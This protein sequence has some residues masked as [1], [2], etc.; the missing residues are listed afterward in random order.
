MLLT[1]VLLV[2]A[3]GG[4]PAPMQSAIDG[5]ALPSS[6]QIAKAVV[7]GGSSPCLDVADAYCPSV[8]RYYTVDGD[9]PDL[10][11]E[12]RRALLEG[13]FGQPS[14]LFPNCD[15]PST[16]GGLCSISGSRGDLRIRVNLYPPGRN[17]GVPDVAV[18]GQA[19]VRITVY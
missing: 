6:W 13:G 5:L 7:R 4:D 2:S 12:A 19:T 15:A 14:E 11:N 9:L 10:F 17:A 8:T 1:L 3:C 18:P 16:N